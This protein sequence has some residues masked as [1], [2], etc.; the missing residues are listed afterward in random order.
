MNT[1]K[2]VAFRRPN[3]EEEALK[4]DVLQMMTDDRS[5]LL[6]RHP[7]VGHLAMH[8]ELIPVIDH[9]MTTACTDGRRIF[10][11]AEYY[12]RKDREERLGILGHEVWHCALR[13]FQRKGNRDLE[14]FNYACDV[15]VDLLLHK[16]GF[17]VEVLPHDPGWEGLSAEQIY[18][19]MFVGLEDFQKNDEHIFASD[20]HPGGR[21]TAGN[22]DKDRKEKEKNE[23]AS[24][25]DAE[26]NMDALEDEGDSEEEGTSENDADGMEEETAKASC[27]FTG[28]SRSQRTSH[29]G[30]ED[31]DYQPSVDSEL[32]DDWNDYLTDTIEK[33]LKNGGKGF[34]SLPGNV[35]GLVKKDNGVASVDWKRVLLDFVSQ[36]FGGERQW[37][38]PSR[39]YVWKGLYLPSRGKKKS[40]EIV[41]AI[42]TSGSTTEDLPDFLSE[43][44]GM[45]AAFGEYKLTIIQCDVA[46]HSVKV[47]SND[48]PLPE[49]G[50]EFHGFGGT[51]FIAPF[52]YVEEKMTEPPT[53]FIYLTD[54]FGNAPERAPDYPVIWCLT[55]NGK[56]PASWGLEVKIKKKA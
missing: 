13:H 30:V 34:G 15:E 22:E 37:L 51:S 21:G 17:K 42:D 53:V 26:E 33:D 45:A 14:K 55:R 7:F 25:D 20:N 24:E 40:I 1:S 39:R 6:E 11:D 10:A 9:R 41:L 23:D 31:P 44:R 47:Y 52:R 3:E 28:T 43:L 54:G 36:T 50:L 16:D 56:K 27:G 12:G 49:D 46:I 18:D 35:T 5:L 2:N 38:P 19:L 8:L 29:E 32:E 48:D 4:K